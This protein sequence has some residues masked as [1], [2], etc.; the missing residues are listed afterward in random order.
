MPLF[1]KADVPKPPVFSAS[2]VVS[3]Q[4]MGE[5]YLHLLRRETKFSMEKTFR[6][7]RA[8]IPKNSIR[9]TI[10]LTVNILELLSTLIKETRLKSVSG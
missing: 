10:T 9:P 5:I 1:N 8:I 4:V 6:E 2:V 7:I 3:H